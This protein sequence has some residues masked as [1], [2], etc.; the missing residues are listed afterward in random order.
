MAEPKF[1]DGMRVTRHPKAPDF[2]KA[3]IGINIGDFLVWANA[4]SKNGWVNIQV[5]ES[6]GG[7][8]YAELDTYEPRTAPQEGGND[9]GYEKTIQVQDTTTSPDENGRVTDMADIPFN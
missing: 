1:V 4:H 5:K 2:V 8:L 7:K 3:S 6:K 9:A